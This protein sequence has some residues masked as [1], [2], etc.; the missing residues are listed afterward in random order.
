[1]AGNLR[2]TVPR[3]TANRVRKMRI[4]FL[5]VAWGR[6]HR[7]LTTDSFAGL[8]GSHPLLVLNSCLSHR[9]A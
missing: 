9:V 8:D 6:L 3:D 4:D 7:A 1:M 2:G 5:M